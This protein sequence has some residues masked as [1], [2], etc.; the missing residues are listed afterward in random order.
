MD[1]LLIKNPYYRV[2]AVLV[3]ELGTMGIDF[4]ELEKRSLD[5]VK[6][7]LPYTTWGSL[8]TESDAE[9][10]KSMFASYQHFLTT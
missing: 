1:E 2:L 7:G 10:L 8:S 4:D 9:I 3:A 5:R 6:T